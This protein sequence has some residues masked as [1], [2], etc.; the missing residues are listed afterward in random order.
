MFDLDLWR[1]IFQSINKNRTRSLLSGFTIAFA[2]LLFTILFGIANGLENTFIEL[3]GTD[4]QNSIVIFPGRTT[5]AHKG[6]QSGRRI[7]FKNEDYDYILEEFGNN[8]EYIT[9]KVNRNVEASFKGAKDSYQVRAVHPEHM[10]IENNIVEKGRYINN[11]DLENRTKVAV[12]GQ[13]IDEDLFANVESI[14]KYINL[15]GIPYKVVGVFSDDEGDNEEKVIYTPITTAQRVYGNNEYIDFIHL[16]YNPK[17]SYDQAIAFGNS[18]TRKLKDKFDVAR[19]DQRAIRVRN[20]AEGTKGV[21]QMMFVLNII[22]LFIGSGT[23]IAGIMGISNIM[24][25]IVK[26]RTKEIGVRKAL[27]ASPRSIVSIILLESILITSIAGYVGLLIGAGVLKLVGPG[28]KEYFI[29]NPGVDTGVVI[30][31][32]IILIISGA[33]AGYLPANKASKIKPIVALRNE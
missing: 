21:S 12:I 10:Y 19:D 7:R 2:I 16:T 6:M 13:V 11:S 24:V 30:G 5:K 28:L 3:F 1:E 25:F 9:S 15:N 29:T 31:A 20:F 4:A 17:L 23:L 27:G 18:L 33:L 14:G 8:V 32:T 26:E 22:V